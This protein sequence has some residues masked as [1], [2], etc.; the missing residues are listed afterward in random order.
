MDIAAIGTAITTVKTAVSI[1]NALQS[2]D[3]LMEKAQLELQIAELVDTLRTAQKELIEVEDLIAS[4]D[5][6]IERLKSALVTKK[7][8]TRVGDAFYELDS[9]GNASGDPLCSACWQRDGKA[10]YIVSD[11]IGELNICPICGGMF[12]QKT[13]PTLKS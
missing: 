9:K 7:I 3:H 8:L 2:A 4:K 11:G 6:E 5:K 10:I 12:D 1:A 13:T